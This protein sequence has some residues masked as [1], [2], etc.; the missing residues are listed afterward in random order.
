MTKTVSASQEPDW[1]R[2]TCAGIAF[3]V[4]ALSQAELRARTLQKRRH[5]KRSAAAVVC[6]VLSARGRWPRRDTGVG[7]CTDRQAEKTA[8]QRHSKRHRHLV[9]TSLTACV[10]HLVCEVAMPTAA[11]AIGVKT[12][13]RGGNYPRAVTIN[14]YPARRHPAP[15]E[16]HRVSSLHFVATRHK[17]DLSWCGRWRR[18]CRSR[19]GRGRCCSRRR[20]S[21]WGCGPIPNRILSERRS[22]L[23]REVINSPV[24]NQSKNIYEKGIHLSIRL[25]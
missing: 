14:V 24:P 15:G 18:S 21:C 16:I 22:A 13:I 8:L 5:A 10:A 12:F 19:P 4:F 7:C 2:W 1:W 25:L 6:A 17:R 3:H 9:R 23:V 20:R 11:I